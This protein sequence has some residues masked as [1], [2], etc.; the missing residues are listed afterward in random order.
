MNTAIIGVGSNIDPKNNISSA[1]KKLSSMLELIKSS[2]FVKT[3]P[4]GYK[5]QDEFLNGAFLVKTNLGLEQLKSV[6]GKI[7]DE[8]GRIRTDNKYGPRT[9]DLDIVI[10]NNEV[11]D[12]EIYSREFLKNSIVELIPGFKF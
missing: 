2:T 12:D 11:I 1:K 4:F 10:W 5:D 9:I 6:L 7:E 8:L 3:A